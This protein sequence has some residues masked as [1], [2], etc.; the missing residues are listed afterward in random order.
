MPTEIILNNDIISSF[1][2]VLVMIVLV[3]M[4]LGFALGKSRK[5]K[6]ENQGEA[7]VRRVLTEYCKK[8]TAHTLNNVTLQYGDGTT[9]IDHLLITQNGILVV[10]TKHYTGWLFAHEKQKQWTQVIYQ[11][12]SKFQNPIFQN[13]KHVRATQ[14]LLDFIPKEQIQSLV[15]FTGD[16]QF[17]T[18]IP[19]GVIHINQLPSYIDDLRFGLISENRVQFCVGRLECK[20]LE[21][22]GKTDIE[23]QMYLEKKFGVTSN[24]E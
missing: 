9:Q 23:H 17:K 6:K 14:Q 15:V 18:E 16:A 12:R 24:Y 7:L 11:V 1:I 5:I 8:S 22:T 20:R 2:A 21:L 13:T 3:S 19:S 4:G 10:E